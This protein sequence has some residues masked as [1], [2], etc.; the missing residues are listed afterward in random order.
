VG[1]R[2]LD[3]LARAPLYIGGLLVGQV[4]GTFGRN[5]HDEAAG[6]E[7]AALWDDGTSGDYGAVSYLRPVQ[8]RR[9]HTDEAIVPDLTPV[10][11]RVVAD[12]TT[13]AD[14]GRESGIGMQDATILDVGP[15]PD[16]NGLRIAA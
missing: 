8:D 5:A 12:H 13:F 10:H 9:A 6:R 2:A 3:V 14:H 11:D 15:G 1:H 7:L 4:A 16:A